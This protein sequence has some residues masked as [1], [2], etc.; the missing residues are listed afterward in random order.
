MTGAQIRST[1]RSEASRPGA[2]G[3]R[4]PGGDQFSAV[5]DSTAHDERTGDRACVRLIGKR[6]KAVHRVV[7]SHDDHV[8]NS[9][10]DGFV[11]A[12]PGRSTR[13]EAESTSSVNCRSAPTTFV[14]AS[15]FTPAKS[16]LPGDDLFGTQRRDGRAGGRYQDDDGEILVIEAVRDVVADCE[17]I[18]VDEVRRG[19]QGLCR[20]V[21]LYTE[22]AW[23]GLAS[24]SASRWCSRARMSSAV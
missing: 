18:A 3:T 23:L 17:D 6:D 2:A 7:D 16:V 21:Q 12:S 11:S 15:A 8:V 20:H 1:R 13:S 19:A 14:H 24:T 5:A 4:W 9:Q 10:G 22:S